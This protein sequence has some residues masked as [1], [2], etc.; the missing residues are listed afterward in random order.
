MRAK[1]VVGNKNTIFLLILGI[2]RRRK[3]FRMAFKK[4]RGA[5]RIY[6]KTYDGQG[7]IAEPPGHT[8]HIFL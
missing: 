7:W 8:Y 5:G 3:E 2:H 1:F 4:S 6:R